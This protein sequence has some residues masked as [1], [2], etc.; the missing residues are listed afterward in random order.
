[1]VVFSIGVLPACGSSNGGRNCP[2]EGSEL[3]GTGGLSG[4]GLGGEG[5]VATGGKTANHTGGSG[6]NIQASGGSSVGGVTG[7]AGHSAETCIAGTTGTEPCGGSAGASSYGGATSVAGTGGSSGVGGSIAIV[8]TEGTGDCDGL[9]QNGCET[10]IANTSQHCGY[11]RH[12]C[13]GGVCVAGTCQPV[14]LEDVGMPSSGLAVGADFIYW[15]TQP[16]DNSTGAPSET[17]IHR[18]QTNG[19]NSGPTLFADQFKWSAVERWE[20]SLSLAADGRDVYWI[21]GATSVTYGEENRLLRCPTQGCSVSG[22]E[23]VATVEY[24]GRVGL[25]PNYI[26]WRDFNGDQ[27]WAKNRNGG[28]PISVA[29]NQSNEGV[30]VAD[31]EHLY[32]ATNGQIRRCPLG[33][34]CDDWAIEVLFESP[35]TI[36]SIIQLVLVDGALYWVVSGRFG[37][38]I[39]AMTLNDGSAP[40]ELKSGLNNPII[41][42]ANGHLF[43]AEASK[44]A[45]YTTSLW[46]CALPNC[47]NAKALVTNEAYPVP[48]L[49]GDSNRLFWIANTQ[50]RKLVLP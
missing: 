3:N 12:D 48:Q 33:V 22:P 4:S 11:C 10:N 37:E 35:G 38:S 7:V 31:A 44:A 45:P 5:G 16:V 2:A 49:T 29:V 19:C 40:R 26:I 14:V 42:V 43:W 8:C 46:G 39:L 32:W 18:C 15:S 1:M 13:E 24:G 17:E 41:H 47:T 27:V 9:A 34:S 50:I 6:T 23:I 25:S 28:T 20:N 21:D 30:I 36:G